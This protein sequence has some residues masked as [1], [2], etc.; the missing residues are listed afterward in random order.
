MCSE[1]VGVGSGRYCYFHDHWTKW[2]EKVKETPPGNIKC[3]SISVKTL[4]NDATMLSGHIG[5]GL[6][7]FQE[8]NCLIPFKATKAVICKDSFLRIWIRRCF[9]VICLNRWRSSFLLLLCLVYGWA[10]PITLVSRRVCVG[11]RGIKPAITWIYMWYM[12]HLMTGVARKQLGSA[13]IQLLAGNDK[14]KTEGFYL[15][16][17]DI[18]CHLLGV[19]IYCLTTWCLTV[20]PLWC[21]FW[22]PRDP[23]EDSYSYLFI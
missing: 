19:L 22:W 8:K 11:R 3:F 13:H 6:V 12:D 20:I 9:P 14:K 21:S 17:F 7:I 18:H 4:I 16:R 15:F 1:Q 10:E 23:W 5:S 2:I